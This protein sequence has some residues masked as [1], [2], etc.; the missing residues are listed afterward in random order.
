[1]ATYRAIA[2]AIDYYDNNKAWYRKLFG[3]QADIKRLKIFYKKLT[4]VP[5][6]FD[7]DLSAREERELRLLLNGAFANTAPRRN[8]L[9]RKALLGLDKRTTLPHVKHAYIPD[10][11]AEEVIYLINRYLRNIRK[12]EKKSAKIINPGE[13]KK[14]ARIENLLERIKFNKSYYTTIRERALLYAGKQPVKKRSTSRRH[15]KKLNYKITTDQFYEFLCL[16]AAD[17]EYYHDPNNPYFSSVKSI[18]LSTNIQVD[19]QIDSIIKTLK[20]INLFNPKINTNHITLSKQLA[21]IILAGNDPTSVYELFKKLRDLKLL[22]PTI[23]QL[24]VE[25]KKF[26]ELSEGIRRLSRMLNTETLQAIVSHQN[27]IELADAFN[28]FGFIERLPERYMIAIA[29]CKKPMLMVDAIHLLQRNHMLDRKNFSAIKGKRD[30][31]RIAKRLV[32]QRDRRNMLSYQANSHAK[33]KM[34]PLAASPVLPRPAPRKIDPEEDAKQKLLL[35][36]RE[37]NLNTVA[38]IESVEQFKQG[39]PCIHTIFNSVIDIYN[40]SITKRQFDRII[41]WAL[42]EDPDNLVRLGDEKNQAELQKIILEQFISLGKKDEEDL[43]KAKKPEQLAKAFMLFDLKE[44][45]LSPECRAELI[46]HPM[47]ALLAEVFCEIGKAELTPDLV[48]AILK[49]PH[50]PN[51]KLG[52]DK[53]KKNKLYNKENRDALIAHEN[54]LQLANEFV[55]LHKRGL[56]NTENRAALIKSDKPGYVRIQIIDQHETAESAKKAKEKAKVKLSPVSHPAAAS[57]QAPQAPKKEDGPDKLKQDVLAAIEPFKD[58]MPCIFAACRIYESFYKSELPMASFTRFIEWAKKQDPKELIKLVGNKR[59]LEANVIM[60]THPP[61]FSANQTIT[62]VQLQEWLT[63]SLLPECRAALVGHPN[64]S[65]LITAF[66][67]VGKDKL[68]PDLISAIAKV[69]SIAQLI[70]GIIALKSNDMYDDDNRAALLAHPHPDRL[71]L[72]FIALNNHILMTSE[73]NYRPMLLTPE[74]HAALCKSPDP[75][76]LSDEIIAK[77]EKV[78]RDKNTLV[79]AV[80]EKASKSITDTFMG[81][82]GG[83]KPK[84]K[85]PQAK[86]EAKSASPTLS[87]KDKK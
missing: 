50:L 43:A 39:F 77:F 66:Y 64:P 21:A 17:Y 78:E 18:T 8:S 81:L 51:L 76:A 69:D 44:E 15:K 86:S 27:P 59:E 30:P 37:K 11:L 79:S 70:R 82:F 73:K 26:T 9:A 56:L 47:P 54:P 36:L 2:Q 46:K 4:P 67:L 42:W 87:P 57:A 29:K 68:T 19:A 3:D 49:A 63:E 23:E 80:A 83:D 71:A 28:Q 58:G 74:N 16:L 55:T 41:N 45:E 35:L 5:A 60:N 14:I 34:A 20:Q 7:R 1:M 12:Y 85:P 53:L 32:D 33:L 62:S 24:I 40:G 6:N 61:M 22:T 25:H 72:G 52:I 38:N 65:D 75:I 10:K 48:R 84:E 13:R 31:L